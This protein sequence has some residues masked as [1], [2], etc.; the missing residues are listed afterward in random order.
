MGADTARGGVRVAGAAMGS[1]TGGGAK[2]MARRPGAAQALT[3]AEAD[4]VAI[5]AVETVAIA[6]S[7][8]TLTLAPGAVAMSTIGNKTGGGNASAPPSPAAEDAHQAARPIDPNRL[9]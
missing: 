8:I 5:G 4:G 9:H 6:D 7:G 1:G 2:R 3:F